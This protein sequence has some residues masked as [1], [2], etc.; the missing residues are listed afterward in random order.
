MSDLPPIKSGCWK[1]GQ[2]GHGFRDCDKPAPGKRCFLC[3]LPGVTKYECPRPSCQQTIREDEAAWRAAAEADQ[4]AAE[5]PPGQGLKDVPEGEND[6]QLHS[7]P[8]GPEPVRSEDSNSEPAAPALNL[9]DQ[10]SVENAL[11]SA[12]EAFL[13]TQLC[14]AAPGY[15]V[16][17]RIPPVEV[18][19]V[20]MGRER[21][22][23]P[24]GALIDLESVID[25][26]LP[27]EEE[28]EMTTD[29]TPQIEQYGHQQVNDDAVLDAQNPDWD[30]ALGLFD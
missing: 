26:P 24:T 15:T 1:C 16:R 2:R 22:D 13:A 19:L 18:E 8:P 4:L 12:L 6:L 27:A 7:E 5:G 10:A 17:L 30:D 21:Q 14:T 28:D 25:T 29:E 23:A 11:R 3:G 20:P 9:I